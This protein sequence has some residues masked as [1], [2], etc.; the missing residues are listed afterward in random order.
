VALLAPRWLAYFEKYTPSSVL[1]SCATGTFFIPPT[2]IGI[3][4]RLYINK[5]WIISPNSSIISV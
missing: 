5:L 2:Y 1:H 4:A 3:R